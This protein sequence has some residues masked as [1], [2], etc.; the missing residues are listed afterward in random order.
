[1]ARFA[2]GWSRFARL[3]G[4]GSDPLAGRFG[5]SWIVIVSLRKPP[6][7]GGGFLGFLGFSRLERDFSMSYTDFSSK[8]FSSPL[9]SGVGSARSAGVAFGMRKSGAVHGRS[10]PLFLISC[11]Q[12]PSIALGANRQRRLFWLRRS[13]PAQSPRRRDDVRISHDGRALLDGGVH[14]FRVDDS[15]R[16][17]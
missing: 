6:L 3:P 7:K 16:L 9:I 17:V 8:E 1:M 12:L 4:G 10:L 2:F 5:L 14:L 11:N 15:V 13:R